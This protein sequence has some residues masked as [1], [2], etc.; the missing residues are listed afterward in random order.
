MSRIDNNLFLGGMDVAHDRKFL[1]KHGIKC[2]ISFCLGIEY[3][4][5]S[6]ETGDFH[7]HF[8]EIKYINI[9]IM[10]HPK[11][12]ISHRLR[13]ICLLLDRYLTAGQ[14]VLLHCYIG[15]SRSAS[16]AIAYIMWKYHLSYKHA[17]RFVKRRSVVDP[18]RGFI[19]ELKKFERELS[20]LT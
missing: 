3:N 5:Y 20:Y 18:N 14:P 9:P 13:E 2:V 16:F 12:I 1:R 11:T 4:L 19:R 15:M 7:P 17:Y 10:D 6:E 8:P